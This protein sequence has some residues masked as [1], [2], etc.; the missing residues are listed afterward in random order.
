MSLYP[1]DDRP[2]TPARSSRTPFRAAVCSDDHLSLI[3]DLTP[4]LSR[5]AKAHHHAGGELAAA[6]TILHQFA[7]PIP[8]T[9]VQSPA[10]IPSV[11]T[12][13]VEPHGSDFPRWCAHHHRAATCDGR[14]IDLPADINLFSIAP[15]RPPAGAAIITRD[16]SPRPLLAHLPSSPRKKQ[17]PRD[18]TSGPIPA[19]AAPW[20]LCNAAEISCHGWWCRSGGVMQRHRRHSSYPRPRHP[21][22]RGHGRRLGGIARD[23]LPT[24]PASA[25]S[26]ENLRPT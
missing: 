14:P 2:P 15:G 4:R 25:V 24:L 13:G 17:E 3:G 23:C 22:S 10:I 19:K 26:A 20:R 16:A 12:S 21:A 7:D 6:S 5:S 9:Q 11:P 18:I 8:P 1:A